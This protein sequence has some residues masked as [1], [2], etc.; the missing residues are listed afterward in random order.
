MTQTGHLS[1]SEASFVD[2]RRRLLI[3]TAQSVRWQQVVGWVRE[4]WE[5]II[6]WEWRRVFIRNRGNSSPGI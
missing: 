4:A 3:M 1:R 6:P 5:E 2:K